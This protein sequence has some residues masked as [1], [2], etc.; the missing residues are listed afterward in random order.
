M[1]DPIL[2]VED[3]DFSYGPLQVL[4]DVNLTVVAGDAVALLGTNGAGKSTLLKVVSGLLTPDRG[5]VRFRGEDVTTLAPEDRATRGMTLIEGGK[6]TFPS[7][8][9]AENIRIGAYP[10]LRDSARVTQ[11][12][13]EVL[14][15]FAPLRSR[16]NQAG[17]TLSGGE[18]QMMAISRALM[19]S[20]ELL[21]IDELSL[22]LAPVVMQE[23]LGVVE[24]VVAAGTTVLLVEQSLNIALSLAQ[25]AYFMEKGAIRFRGATAELLDRGDLVRSVFFG[26]EKPVPT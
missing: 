7:L 4:F 13:D 5:T 25:D 24:R 20:P 23:I 17:G 22:G 8:T 26:A 1:K 14:D 6:A 2:E 9:V 15:L 16:V 19:A 11:R 18:Q 3:L 10:F 12:F 21:L